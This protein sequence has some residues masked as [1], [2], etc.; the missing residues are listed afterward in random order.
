MRKSSLWRRFAY[1]LGTTLLIFAATWFYQRAETPPWRQELQ[2]IPQFT[3]SVTQPNQPRSKQSST[4]AFRFVSYNLKNWLTSSQN[5]EKSTESKN[6]IVEILI[7]GDADIIGLSEIGSEADV[8]EIQKLLK[9][10]GKDLPHSYHTGG[11]DP[12]R[13]LAIL[14]RFPI[15]STTQ[16]EITITGTEHS[17]QRGILDASIQIHDQTIRF[18]GVHLKSKRIVPD[19]N[20]EEIRIREAEHVR[21][22]IDSILSENPETHLIAYGDF[23]DHIE[24]L[25]TKTI[26]GNY[27]SQNY[28]APVNISDQNGE[29]WTYHFDS[30]DSYNRI[31]FITVSKSLKPLID[32]KESR[33]IATPNW[34]IAS[35]HRAVMVSFD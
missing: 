4:A 32:Q 33:I 28:L 34:Q 12:I 29:N 21:K 6:A 15:V 31:D 27:R 11:T 13:H 10:A 1:C 18:I 30:Q 2:K 9:Q 8:L 23:N 14:S 25:S 7:A 16:P 26:L 5:P 22:H 17:M 19:Y 20:Q 24:S 35:D 3:G